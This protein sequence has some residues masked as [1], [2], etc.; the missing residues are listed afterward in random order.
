MDGENIEFVAAPVSIQG[1]R[2]WNDM[3]IDD[4]VDENFSSFL[5]SYLNSCKCSSED[6]IHFLDEFAKDIEKDL[7]ALEN[8]EIQILQFRVLSF[9]V[10]FQ[11]KKK[12]T[13]FLFPFDIEDECFDFDHEFDNL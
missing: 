8:Q 11:Q 12:D 5:S 2:E 7:E 4:E 10:S 6:K 9:E 1:F 3:Y 13:L